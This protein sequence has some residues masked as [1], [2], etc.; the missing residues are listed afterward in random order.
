[1]RT[2]FVLLA[3][4]AAVRLA[5]AQEVPPLAGKELSEFLGPVSPDVVR[6]TKSCGLDFVVYN[7][8]ALPPLKGHVGFYVGSAPSPE[9]PANAAIVYGRLGKYPAKWHRWNDAGQIKQQALIY[10]RWFQ[11]VDIWMDAPQQSDL[12]QLSTIVARLPIFNE[13][14]K[15]PIVDDTLADELLDTH[16]SLFWAVLS[17][18]PVFFL[19][20]L[21]LVA[22]R[23]RKRQQKLSHRA[24][25][26]ASYCLVFLM[27]TVGIL[28]VCAPKPFVRTVILSHAVWL[29]LVYATLLALL[30][31]VVFT[32][33]AVIARCLQR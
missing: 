23:L 7:G 4:F 24:S 5:L 8:E 6:W 17:S 12:D 27:L 22:H 16:P 13:K 18:V 1:V 3:L 21:W 19:V 28:W 15:S 32:I 26:L 25:W 2:R 33:G 29:T 9:H 11:V 14:P 30:F 10:M 20:G 31:L